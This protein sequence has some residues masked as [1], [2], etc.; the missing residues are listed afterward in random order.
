MKLILPALILFVS[1]I[2]VTGLVH[3]K[4]HN[5]EKI[6]EKVTEKLSLNNQQQQAFREFVVAKQNLRQ[7][8]KQERK[9]KNNS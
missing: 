9:E 6:V 1:A 5:P 7:E 4:S 2:A 8:M 3:A